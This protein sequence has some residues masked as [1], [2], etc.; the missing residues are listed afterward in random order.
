MELLAEFFLAE[1]NRKEETA[2]RWSEP[3]L[4]RL[5]EFAGPGNVRELRHAAEWLGIGLKTLYNRL[6]VY[7]AAQPGKV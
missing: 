7:A 3:A 1:V 6:A 4:R 5:R 2:K